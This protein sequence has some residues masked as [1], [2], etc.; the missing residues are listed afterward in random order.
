MQRGYL[1]VKEIFETSDIGLA[2]FLKCSG[3]EIKNT[4]QHKGNIGFS[5]IDDPGR[6]E[7]VYKYFNGRGQVDALGFKIVACP[8]APLGKFFCALFPLGGILRGPAA[9]IRSLCSRVP[10]KSAWTST[11][12]QTKI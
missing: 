12:Y 9:H 4:I 10:C 2:A 7:L 3:L 5:F 1:D 11:R 6:K 8:V